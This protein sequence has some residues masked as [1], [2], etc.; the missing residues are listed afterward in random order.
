MRRSIWPA[1]KKKGRREQENRG[2][3]QASSAKE[4]P[5]LKNEMQV[6]MMVLKGWEGPGGERR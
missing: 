6:K 5:C 3:E 1:V 2:E 4:E